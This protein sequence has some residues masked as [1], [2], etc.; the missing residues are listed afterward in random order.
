[1]VRRVDP[2]S[3]M[4]GCLGKNVLRKPWATIRESAALEAT[5]DAHDSFDGLRPSI[6]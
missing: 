1:M 6:G 5:A 4:H 2:D 3:C